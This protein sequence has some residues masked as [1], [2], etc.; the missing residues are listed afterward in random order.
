MPPWLIPIIYAAGSIVCSLVLPSVEI[1]GHALGISVTSAQAFLSAAASGMMALTG[2]VFAIAFVMVQFSAIAYSPR[3]ALWFARDQTLFH[4]LGAFV[5]TFIYSVAALAWIDRYG[6]GTVPVFSV[7][8][9]AVLLILSMLLFSWLVQ[10]LRDLQ[11]VKV[12]QRPTTTKGRSRT[13]RRFLEF[14]WPP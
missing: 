10:R 13:W 12:L 8:L 9:V 7:L 3:L 2:I 5:A 4:S 6:A 14:L 1:S 11:I